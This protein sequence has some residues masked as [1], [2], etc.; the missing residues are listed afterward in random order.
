MC[1][2][3]TFFTYWDTLIKQW[4]KNP[5][6]VIKGNVYLSKFGDPASS[7]L[8]QGDAGD[9]YKYRPEPYLGDPENCCAVMLNLNPGFGV[10]AGVDEKTHPDYKLQHCDAADKIHYD[11]KRFIPY[12]AG[13]FVEDPETCVKSRE[14]IPGGVFWWNGTYNSKENRCTGGRID[15][16]HHLYCLYFGTKPDR[17]PFVLEICPWHSQSLNLGYIFPNGVPTDP[18]DQ[19]IKV[20]NDNVISPALLA[21]K[22]N[23]TLPFVI[24]IGNVVKEL[25]DVLTLETKPEWCWNENSGMKQWPVRKDGKRVKRT[26]TLY[27]RDGCY[28]LNISAPGSNKPPGKGPFQSEIEPEILDYIKSII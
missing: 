20:I 6:E 10:P 22:E 25:A 12:L 18:N 24:C 21:T 7:P 16:I 13:E 14:D 5:D 23:N 27:H 15:Y 9:F 1:N 19:L 4:Y 28:L 11:E 2:F 17:L 8:Y 3:Q 26:Y